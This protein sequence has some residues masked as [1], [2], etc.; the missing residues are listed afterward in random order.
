MSV[1]RADTTVVSFLGPS[2]TGKTESLKLIF[3]ELN[4]SGVRALNFSAGTVFRGL[5]EHVDLGVPGYEKAVSRVLGKTSVKIDD[6]GQVSLIYEGEPFTQTLK[7]GQT[8][9]ALGNNKSIREM[10][11]KFLLEEVICQAPEGPIIGYDA[12]EPNF[13]P[14]NVSFVFHAPMR[15]RGEIL[16]NERDMRGSPDKVIFDILRERDR[17]EANL[18]STLDAT[19][20]GVVHVRRTDALLDHRVV[21]CAAGIIVDFQKGKYPGRFGTITIN[22]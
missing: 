18:L 17:A 21:S 2:S 1:E 15:V 10:V 22:A 19:R 3:K 11:Q 7:N 6:D 9:A 8:A 16:R 20:R 14:T 5:A 13:L 4:E 12:R